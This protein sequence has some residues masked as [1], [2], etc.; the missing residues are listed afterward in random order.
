MTVL[1]K[2]AQK[3]Q[4]AL[5]KYG[6]DLV[7]VELPDSTRTALE[8]AESIGCTV[9]QIVKSLIF[10]GSQSLKPYL[11]LVSGENRADEK[12]LRAYAG[13]KFRRADADFVRSVTGYAIGGVPPVGHLQP[14]NTYIDEDLMQYDVIWAAA[15]TDHAVFRLTPA[16]L[17]T[18]TGGSVVGL[19]TEPAHTD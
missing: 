5:T 14:M 19:K 13:E 2:S 8:A 11:V 1:S 12:R 4:D 3:V 15:G 16:Q 6:L 9:G 18:V 7:V 10:Q 17:Q